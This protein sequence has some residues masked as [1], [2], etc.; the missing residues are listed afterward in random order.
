[1]L[2]FDV[3]SL[4]HFGVPFHKLAIYL[5]IKC[6]CM[7]VLYSL[8][9]IKLFIICLQLAYPEWYTYLEDPRYENVDMFSKGTTSVVANMRENLNMR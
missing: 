5:Y 7:G 1:M 3:Y 8:V 6:V 4:R 9:P 2:I